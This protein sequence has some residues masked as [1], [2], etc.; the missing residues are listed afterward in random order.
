MARSNALRPKPMDREVQKPLDLL[1]KVC[2]RPRMYL[3]NPQTP[4]SA[5]VNFVTGYLAAL[6]TKDAP[7]PTDKFLAGFGSAFANWLLQ[8]KASKQLVGDPNIGWPGMIAASYP[9]EQEQFEA[10]FKLFDEFIGTIS[11]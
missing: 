2:R 1:Q 3:W 5:L 8:V 6:Q 4:F 9:T 11:A 7:S 10:F